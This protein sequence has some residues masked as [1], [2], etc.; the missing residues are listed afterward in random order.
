MIRRIKFK[1]RL[2]NP[3]DIVC[4]ITEEE[5]KFIFVREIETNTP[6]LINRKDIDEILEPEKETKK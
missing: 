2:G 6:L 4:D 5:K 3:M 1:N